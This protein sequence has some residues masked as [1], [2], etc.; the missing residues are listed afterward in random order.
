[1]KRHWLLLILVV[2]FFQLLYGL[3]IMKICNMKSAIEK[4][5]NTNRK[6]PIGTA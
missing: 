6:L 2:G 4:E 1:M 3:R 5:Q